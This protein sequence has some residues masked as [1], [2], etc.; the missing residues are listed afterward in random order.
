LT[1]RAAAGFATREPRQRAT[2]PPRSAP[3]ARGRGS[4]AGSRARA[5]LTARGLALVA[6][7]LAAG[8][9]TGVVSA[10]GGGQSRQAQLLKTEFRTVTVTRAT[11]VTPAPQ[12]PAATAA[13]TPQTSGAPVTFAPVDVHRF[14]LATEIPTGWAVHTQKYPHRQRVTVI[15]PA[16]QTI[17]I[18]RTAHASAPAQIDHGYRTISLTRWRGGSVSGTLW[19][20]AAPFCSSVCSDWI[21]ASQRA[22]YAV[23]IDSADPTLVHEAMVVA[24]ALKELR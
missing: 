7:A 9:I 22:G 21:G 16:G 5:S 15:G 4:G 2:R 12:P 19:R 10:G 8:V 13:P 20:F 18:D 17:V 1:N 24:T 3:R 23:L 6:L 11:T 14:A